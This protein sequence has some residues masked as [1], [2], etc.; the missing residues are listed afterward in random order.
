MSAKD[1]LKQIEGIG[2]GNNS[3]KA[4]ETIK[5]YREAQAAAFNANSQSQPLN[6]VWTG[7][8]NTTSSAASRTE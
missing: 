8:Q 6:S 4:Y 7:T 2:I 5:K 1:Y 3:M